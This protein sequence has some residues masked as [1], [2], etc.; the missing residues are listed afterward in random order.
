M[1]SQIY[2]PAEDSYFFSEFLKK[3]LM[4]LK[5]KE[6]SYLDMGCGSGILSETVE[7]FIDKKNILA[8]DI[9]S[10][11]V[12][13]VKEKGFSV[14]KSNLFENVEGD[15]DLITFNAPYLP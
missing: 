3:Y 13:F 11:A 2:E 8:V 1:A 10:A 6:I 12:E 14:V 15:F 5:N 7:K 4:K 9:N